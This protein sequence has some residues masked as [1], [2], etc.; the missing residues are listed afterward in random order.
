MVWNLFLLLGGLI[1]LAVGGECLVKGAARLAR[2]LGVPALVVGLTVVAFGTS[3][4]EIA[5]SVTASINDQ[6]DIAV[7]NVVGSN[8]SNI[9]LVLGLAAM[10]APMKVS[11]S[12]MRFDLPF[13]VIVLAVFALFAL[14]SFS[15]EHGLISRGQ[16]IFFLVALLAYLLFTYRAS[17]RESAAVEREYEAGIQESGSRVF[18]V[19][20]VILGMAAL[21]LGA[22]LIVKGAVGLAS[23]YLDERVIGLTIIAIGTSLPE[24]T[25]CI[26]AAR[27]GQ[28]DIAIGNIVGSNI[29]NILAVIGIASTISPLS[30]AEIILFRDAP[31]MLLVGVLSFPIMRTGHCITRKEGAL[32]VGLYLIYVTWLVLT[33]GGD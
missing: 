29:F 6:D 33:A 15:H 30:V 21:I 26:V 18:N 16:G 19:L 17:R 27:R 28:P 23:E 1:L 8:I 13:M 12:V 9:L 7:A 14:S 5:V 11:R 10:A 32:L 3:S 4:P 25:T 24:M 20:L 2:S 22:D 31:V